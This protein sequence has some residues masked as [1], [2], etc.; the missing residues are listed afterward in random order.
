MNRRNALVAVLVCLFGLSPLAP[1]EKQLDWQVGILR[2]S[3]RSRFFAGTIGDSNSNGNATAYGNTATYNE[4]TNTSETP[5]YRVYQTYEIEG[6]Q[7]VYLA[8]QHIKW[9]WSKAA[10]IAVNGRIQYAVDKRKLY[11]VDD[12]R[13]VYELQIVKKVLKTPQSAAK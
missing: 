2:D 10:D 12:Q 7:Y 4:R 11:L 6:D 5:I 1:A 3:E 8:Q 9:R 13:K